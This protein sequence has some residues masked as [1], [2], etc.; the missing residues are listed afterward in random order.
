V[1]APRVRRRAAASVPVHRRG[2]H[3]AADHVR[4]RTRHAALRL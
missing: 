2:R 4:R 1:D 3:A